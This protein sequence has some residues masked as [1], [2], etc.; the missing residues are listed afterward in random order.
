MAAP[1]L[2]RL[3]ALR[4]SFATAA[5]PVS[6]L[7]GIDLDVDAGET[8]AVMGPSGSGKSTLM[9]ILGC[10]DVPSSGRY[11][12]DGRDVG[13]LDGDERARLRNAFIGFVFQGFHLLPRVNLLDNVALPLLYARVKARERYA[14]AATALERVGLKGFEAYLPARV[15]GGQ[16]QRVA[17]AR[18]L[19][20]RPR[21]ILAD[22]PT[23]N[24]DS[25][26]S[27]EIMRLFGSLNAS[28]GITLVL[29]TH[30]ADIAAYARRLIQMVD[31]RITTMRTRPA[32][33]AAS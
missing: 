13:G 11:L 32:T 6:V 20:N 24:L 12:L 26:T 3:E 9:N 2:I 27:H 30:E 22:E 7:N 15:S 8:L 33:Q 4:K 29:V 21:L 14:R 10:L 18:A 17:I 1:P 28:D 5:G 19:V 25:A 16:Q 23:G 31:G